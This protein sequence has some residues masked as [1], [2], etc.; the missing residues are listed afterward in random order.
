MKGIT[1]IRDYSLLFSDQ[2]AI[3]ASGATASTNYVDQ[4][5]MGTYYNGTSITQGDAQGGKDL[6]IV[7]SC[8]TAATGTLTTTTF[9]VESADDSSF[10]TNLTT[11]FTTAAIAK[12]SLIA[13]ATPVRIQWPKGMRRYVR[14]KYTTDAVATTG[15][16]DAQAVLYADQVAVHNP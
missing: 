1:M 13:G 16:Y 3:T 11:A 2:Q 10:S 9:S 8:N 15:K 14:V 12:A 7:I 5:L 6:Y 4:G